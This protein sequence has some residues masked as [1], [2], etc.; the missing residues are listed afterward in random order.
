MGT[1]GIPNFVLLAYGRVNI[2]PGGAG[3]AA[4]DTQTGPLGGPVANV[5]GL[6][7][8]ATAPVWNAV[9]TVTCR[10]PGI[11]AIIDQCVVHCQ[12]AGARVASELQ[13]FGYACP[14][15]DTIQFTLLQEGAAGAVSALTDWGNFTFAISGF[16]TLPGT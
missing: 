8:G 15:A 1:N 4:Y 14:T 12:A 13:G 11:G 5:G 10:I 3:P 9:G 2:T 16:T 7:D 6:T